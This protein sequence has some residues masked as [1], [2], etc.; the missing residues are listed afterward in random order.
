MPA[1]LTLSLSTV[2]GFLLVLTRVGGVMAFVPFPGNRNVFSVTKAVFALSVTMALY[3]RWPSPE[4]QG[5]FVGLLAIWVLA[6]GVIGLTIGLVVSIVSEGILMTFQL[7]GLQAGYTYASTVDPTTNADSSVLQILGQLASGLLFFG[8][9]LHQDV[10]RAFVYSLE[11]H[12][13]GSVHATAAWAPRLIDLSSGL[14]VT[15][16]QLAMPVMATLMLVDIS[17]ALLGRLNAQIQ[18]IQIAFPM[19]MLVALFLLSWVMLLVLRVYQRTLLDALKAM[20]LLLG[21]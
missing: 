8:F 6:E 13:P 9:N 19:K 20:R 14:F 7:L 5:P 10:L 12:P 11:T 15:G 4:V 17:L 1:E 3:A 16:I 18:L 21:S 2:F